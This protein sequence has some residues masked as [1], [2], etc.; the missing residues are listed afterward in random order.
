MLYFPTRYYF[1]KLSIHKGESLKFVDW[2][3]N[4]RADHHHNNRSNENNGR[5]WIPQKQGLDHKT[6]RETE[7]TDSLLLPEI[8]G[9][10]RGIP[11]LRG[12]LHPDFKN[13][14]K[15]K[16][17]YASILWGAH[18]SL[19]FS[20]NFVKKAYYYWL[21]L[22]VKFLTFPDF[23]YPSH[24]YCYSKNC[25]QSLDYFQVFY[26]NWSGLVSRNYCRNFHFSRNLKMVCYYDYSGIPSHHPDFLVLPAEPPLSFWLRRPFIRLANKLLLLQEQ[27][28]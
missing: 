23:Y 12:F 9:T 5:P 19:T 18:D 27:S 13:E 8:V 24:S 10:E 21:S 25:H 26:W 22:L 28:S 4:C 7:A 1:Q 3:G 17:F 16:I 14:S 11:E 20:A 15:G 2:P 6:D